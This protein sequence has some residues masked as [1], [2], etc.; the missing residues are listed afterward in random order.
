MSGK[1]RAL[2]AE[3]ATGSLAPATMS[4]GI[5]MLESVSGENNSATAGAVPR[6]ALPAW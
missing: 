1:E 4:T 3:G 5:E 2:V 6:L